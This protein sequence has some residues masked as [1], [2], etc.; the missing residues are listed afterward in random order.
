[1]PKRAEES[2]SFRPMFLFYAFAL[3]FICVPVGVGAFTF[4]YGQGHSYL[5]SD[6]RACINCHIMNDQYAAWAMGD[7]RS[8]AKCN[9]CHL[10]RRVIGHR[11]SR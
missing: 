9:D 4:F 5:S 7:H 6:P 10:P 3:V 2:K 1:M 11:R 8:F